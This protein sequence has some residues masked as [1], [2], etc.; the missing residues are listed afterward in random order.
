MSGKDQPSNA[1]IMEA[2]TKMKTEV[3]E[4]INSQISQLKQTIEDNNIKAEEK[5]AIFENHLKDHDMK[6]DNAYKRE[7][8]KNI[9]VYGWEEVKN[10]PRYILRGKFLELL[11]GRLRLQEV[12]GFDI[13]DVR[14]VGPKKNIVVVTVCSAYL[15]HLI[16]SKGFQLAGSKI[17]LEHDLSREERNVKKKLLEHK[18]QF[19]D[20]AQTCKI[21]QNSALVVNGQTYTLEQLEARKGEIL[22][23]TAAAATAAATSESTKKRPR[24]EFESPE[25]EKNKKRN[26]LELSLNT[27]D[28]MM[29]DDNDSIENFS[30]PKSQAQQTSE[31]NQSQTLRQTNLTTY[32]QNE[33]TEDQNNTVIQTTENEKN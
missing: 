27:I 10:Q 17:F 3:N 28:I 26:N 30:T 25:D 6:F 20:I 14:I 9:V 33:C 7:V 8:R 18:K 13:H 5:N 11:H 2:I 16:I 22:K 12:R 29:T 19:K 23:A 32:F 15:A 1:D 21:T 31:S 4:N 24:A